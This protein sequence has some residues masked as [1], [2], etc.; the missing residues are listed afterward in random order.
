MYLGSLSVTH[1]KLSPKY[2]LQQGVFPLEREAQEQ[3]GNSWPPTW[4][5]FPV[6]KEKKNQSKFQKAVVF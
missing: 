6:T 2:C 4:Q 3:S 1:T 5:T